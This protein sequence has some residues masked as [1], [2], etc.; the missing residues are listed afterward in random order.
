LG[1]LLLFLLFDWAL[2]VLSCIVGAATIV[3]NAGSALAASVA[4][5]ILAAPGWAEPLASSE[6]L[7]VL[8]FAALVILGILFQ[9][10]LRR[11]R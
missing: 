4:G 10:S 5:P 7:W 3:Q 11:R 9:A 2:I 6:A 8:V 1:A